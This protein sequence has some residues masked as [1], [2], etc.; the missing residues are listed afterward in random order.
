MEWLEAEC[1]RI[2]RCFY[3]EA[4]RKGKFSGYAYHTRG[5]SIDF[6]KPNMAWN[7]NCCLKLGSMQ[8]GSRV[9]S[10][11][12]EESVGEGHKQFTLYCL[13]VL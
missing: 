12:L 5:L 7:S 10:H 3:E 8:Y 6:E 1:G 9:Q 13:M 11:C 2:Q 4:Q